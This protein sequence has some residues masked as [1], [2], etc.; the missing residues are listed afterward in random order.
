MAEERKFDE[1]KLLRYKETEDPILFEEIL[2]DKDIKRYTLYVCNQ[3]LKNYPTS[4]LSLEDFKNIADLVLWQCI[5]KYKF[6]CPV[7]GLEAKSE[8]M[9]KLHMITKHEEYNEPAVSISKYVKFNLGAYLQNELRKEYSID[10]QANLQTTSLFSPAENNKHDEKDNDNYS[11]VEYELTYDNKS[12]N[13]FLFEDSMEKL[14]CKFDV[15][16]KEIFYCLYKL[17]MKQVDIA[18]KFF[19]DGKYSS[20]QSAKV[21]ISRIIKNKIKPVV[22]DFYS[23][24]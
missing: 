6:I 18:I 16:T 14:M 11:S 19:N 7:C 21:V 5:L 23:K 24:N 17:N 10:R 13:D 12:E 3:K 20:E 2:K 9:Y 15:V 1:A 8:S 22:E 4:L